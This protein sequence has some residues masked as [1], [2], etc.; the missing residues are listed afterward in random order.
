MSQLK[1]RHDGL[2]T[3]I[4]LS[5]V[6]NTIGAALLE[7]LELLLEQCAESSESS[8]LIIYGAGQRFFSPGLDLHEV[9]QL[10]RGGMA[11][12]MK[13]F[14]CLCLRLF[15][16]P[17]PVLA[18]LNG[19]ALAGGFL[20]AS[21][22]DFRY[23]R[24]RIKVGLTELSRSVVMPF[25]SLKILDFL[26]GIDAAQMITRRGSSLSAS[27]AFHIGWLDG[28]FEREDLEISVRREALELTNETGW[29]LRRARDAER[30]QVVEQIRRA[31]AQHLEVFLEHWFSEKAQREIN[32]MVQVLRER[33]Q[34][35]G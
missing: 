14:S 30:R 26:V 34:S 16:Y 13:A 21:C 23:G 6:N 17:K 22:C 7:E 31:E 1:T 25:G 35:K 3:W 9:S 12:F 27:Q 4:G 33:N 20:I 18:M 29:I 19:D 24:S 32:R 11:D 28:I 10:D 8:A 5:S 15:T 2:L